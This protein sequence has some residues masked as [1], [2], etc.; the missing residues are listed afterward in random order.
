MDGWFSELEN[1][2]RFFGE[3]DGFSV[4]MPLGRHIAVHWVVLI[5]IWSLGERFV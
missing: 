4:D 3:D 1:P 2:N 5:W